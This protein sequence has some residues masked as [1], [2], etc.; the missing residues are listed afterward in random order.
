MI[1]EH[2]RQ[3]SGTQQ[4][5]P[6]HQEKLQQQVQHQQPQPQQILPQ[7]KI[8]DSNHRV[9][10]PIEQKRRLSRTPEPHV[11]KGIGTTENHNK[12]PSNNQYLRNKSPTSRSRVCYKRNISLLF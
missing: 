5:Q 3:L 10:Q 6:T 9:E 1:D 12:S 2:N 8:I 7:Q 11:D 4:P